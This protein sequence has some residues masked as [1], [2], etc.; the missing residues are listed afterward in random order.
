MAEISLLFMVLAS[1]KVNLVFNMVLG[2]FPGRVLENFPR[3]FSGKFSDDC[4]CPGTAHALF[5]VI[6][7]YDQIVLRTAH[8][9]F[10]VILSYDQIVLR[11]AHALIEKLINVNMKRNV[12]MKNI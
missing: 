2:Q 7:S 4:F 6:L 10:N 5:N 12:N 11:T 9:L 3:T 1:N 8:A